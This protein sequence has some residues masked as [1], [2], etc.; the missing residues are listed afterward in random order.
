MHLHRIKRILACLAVAA[1]TA[2]V[3]VST[4][5]FMD[6]RWIL[7][8]EPQEEGRIERE[9]HHSAEVEIKPANLEEVAQAV[10]TEPEKEELKKGYSMKI[11]DY[12]V[13][14]HN[15]VNY[16]SVNAEKILQT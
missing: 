4:N 14:S 12:I 5:R 13:I 11:A 9:N 1:C 3:W 8:E 2:L 6:T 10:L 15:G 16:K 7:T